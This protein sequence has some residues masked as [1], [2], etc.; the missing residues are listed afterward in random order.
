MRRDKNVLKEI[1]SRLGAKIGN[2][3]DKRWGPELGTHPHRRRWH[4][5]DRISAW[6]YCWPDR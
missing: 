4:R 5:I 3:N 1:S 2:A 6:L